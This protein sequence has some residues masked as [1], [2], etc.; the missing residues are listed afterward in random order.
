LSAVACFPAGTASPVNAAISPRPCRLS[1]AQDN[2]SLMALASRPHPC[3]RRSHRQQVLLMQW[4]VT[5]LEILGLV[6]IG[7]FAGAT[8]LALA[9]DDERDCVRPPHNDRISEELSGCDR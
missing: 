6:S 7:L 3:Y 4:R 8:G 5:M 2:D 1:R 9:H